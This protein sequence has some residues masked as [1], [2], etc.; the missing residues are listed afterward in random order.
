[1]TYRLTVSNVPAGE[2]DSLGV[3]WTHCTPQQQQQGHVTC[4]QVLAFPQS[5]APL[6]SPKAAYIPNFSVSPRVAHA[7]QPGF[8]DGCAGGLEVSWTVEV[9]S[10]CCCGDMLC[11]AAALLLPCCCC[12]AAAA[13]S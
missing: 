1:M 13:V 10:R 12:C 9:R 8:A 11:C 6:P 2:A 7:L 4:T 3:E 5:T